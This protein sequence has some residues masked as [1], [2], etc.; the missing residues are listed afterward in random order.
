MSRE[1]DPE[2]V[3]ELLHRLFSAFDALTVAHGVYKVETIGARGGV[4]GAPSV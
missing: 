3:M 1:A 4:G 2:A